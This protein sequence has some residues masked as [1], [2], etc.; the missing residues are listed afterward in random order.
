M[1]EREK[2]NVKMN[3]VFRPY[4]IPIG[5][6]VLLTIMFF[7]PVLF[8]GTTFL[9]IGSDFI[10]FNFPNDMFGARSLQQG[11]I[12][13][14]NPYVANGQPYA[15]DPNI[16]FFYPLRMLLFLFAFNYQWMTYSLIF[17]YFLA[18]T[19]TYLLA[20]DMGA[21]EWGSFA[22]GIGFMFTGIFVGQMD[23]INIIYSSIWMPLVFLLFRRSVLRKQQ[24]YALLAGLILSLSILG[25]HQQ[26]SL[27]IGY[28]CSLWV[29]FYLI[30]ARGKGLVSS[31]ISLVL[32][33]IVSLAASAIQIL[34]T[35][36]FFQYSKRA[37]MSISEATNYSTPPN[38]WLLLIFPHFFGQN[39]LEALPFWDV[40]V[41]VNEFYMYVGI[42]I[43]F[44]AL[45]GSYVW[46]NW[47]KWFLVAVVVLSFL[48]TS[49]SATPIYKLAFQLVPGMQMVRVPSRFVFWVDSALILLAAF[50]I[51][52]LIT[53]A[54]DIND[55]IWKDVFKILGFG[56]MVSLIY[57]I[58]F[59]FV[60]ALQAIN[61]HPFVERM[62]NY[63]QTDALVFAG[64]ML[65]MLVIF[66]LPRKWPVF[67]K[68]M[69]FLLIL[70]LIIDLF[71]AQQ[72]RHFIKGDPLEQFTHPE[73]LAFLQEDSDPYR[74][75]FTNV[76][77]F[78]NGWNSLTGF[79]NGYLQIRGLPWNPF[80]LQTIV[81]YQEVS[82][83]N[84]RFYDFRGAKYLVTGEDEQVPLDW[85]LQLDIPPSLAL[86]ENK[87]FLPR[88]FMVYSAFVE[89]N[90]E[91]A[92]KMIQEEQYD[93]AETVMLAGG[94]PFTGMSGN[95]RVEIVSMDNS[96]LS[97]TVDTDRPGYL[98][99]S[100]T[101]YPGWRV[102]VN[103][104]VKEIVRANHAFKAVFLEAGQTEV[105]F[106]YKSKPVEWGGIISLTV[107]MLVLVWVGALWWRKKKVG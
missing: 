27:Y 31:I 58:V 68:W 107:W 93:P 82:D 24:A 99:V 15:A 17:H 80:D 1:K 72:P 25:G 61:T 104:Q 21:N 53:K 98:V 87:N 46:R 105:L 50:G 38:G 32:L 62:N 11:D 85:Q 33:C 6:L 74:V 70:L 73:I 48:L 10:N 36:E 96:L 79:L 39:Y 86:Y 34:P 75:D 59:P 35:V 94:E 97:L 47:E 2:M 89:P 13:L 64:F 12:P 54:K 57:W 81:D 16:G 4:L 20:L 7:A 19:F 41:N 92:L 63:R 49:G 44:A 23:H 95:G 43:L 90:R 8:S 3:K 91:Q 28:W 77:Y 42:V 76:A 71:R 30:Q 40:F 18:G 100:D 5:L 83:F 65:A 101:Y 29:V 88:A 22:A 45:V 106:H 52:W 102:F 84:S 66:M 67:S 51:D 56:V 55:P 37:I 26:F 103:G 78:L 14:W 60:P 9:P 69:P